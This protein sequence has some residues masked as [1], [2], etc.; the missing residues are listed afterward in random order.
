MARPIIFLTQME[1][2]LDYAAALAERPAPR[3]CRADPT[4]DVEATMPPVKQRFWR[5][6]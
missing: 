3:L 5:M 4:G 6:C 2:G 1:Q